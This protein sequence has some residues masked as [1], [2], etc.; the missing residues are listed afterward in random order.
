MWEKQ[1]H[2]NQIFEGNPKPSYRDYSSVEIH[3]FILL[4]CLKAMLVAYQTLSQSL[5]YSGKK[6]FHTNLMFEGM[7]VSL[8]RLD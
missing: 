4:Q 8:L 5:V 3:T 7:Y 1:C 2:P 6:H